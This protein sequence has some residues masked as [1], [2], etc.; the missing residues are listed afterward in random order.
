MLTS[1]LDCFFFVLV[2]AG[3]KQ[4]KLMVAQIAPA[5]RVAIAETAGLAPGDVTV[6]QLVTA[7]RML[8]FD[9]VFGECTCCFVL[10]VEMTGCTC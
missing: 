6:G 3:D 7:L 5:V 9:Y 1:Y 2:F 8:G 10:V 4:G